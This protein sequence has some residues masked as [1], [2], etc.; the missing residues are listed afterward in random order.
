MAELVERRDLDARASRD[1]LAGMLGLHPRRL[2]A[3]SPDL[4]ENMASHV[5]VLNRRLQ[6]LVDSG[7][8]DEMTGA[9]RR[10]PGMEAMERE[11][12]RAQR[13]GDGALVAVFVDVDGL[14]RVN[15]SAGHSAGD[16]LIR[17]MATT[18]RRRLRAY[19]LVIRWGGDEFICV[20]PEAGLN[21]ARRVIDGIEAEFER[22]SAHTFSAG[23]AQIEIGES[24]LELV[25]RAD[26]DLYAHRGRRAPVRAGR[27]A[28]RA[29]ILG[30][31]TALASI[32]PTVSAAFLWLSRILR[33]RRS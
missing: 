9:L 1:H 15:D 23:L 22:S 31:S 33:L 18:L 8:V 32:G 6:V 21:A 27:D 3:L 24:A 14:K 2:A 10:V 11:M 29:G 4:V 17:E 30:W 20:L 7:S 5:N 28:G 13:F 25:A 26:A 19:D 12:H 16:A